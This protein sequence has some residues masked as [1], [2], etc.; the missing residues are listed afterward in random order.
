MSHH[1]LG[2]LP[3]SRKW[4]ESASGNPMNQRA[5]YYPYIH[6]HDVNWLKATLLLFFEVRRMLPGNFTPDDSEEVRA[7][8]ER[9]PSLLSG[10]DLWTR[11]AN[12]AQK[13]LA[14]RLSADAQD[15]T[16]LERSMYPEAVEAGFLDEP[17]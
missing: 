17:D 7:F 6:I 1:E 14:R 5:L 10:A 16:F 9:S 2:R 8:A 15:A 13:A 4:R 12:A 11:R 3:E